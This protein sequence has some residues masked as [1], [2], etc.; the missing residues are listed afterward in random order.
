MSTITEFFLPKCKENWTPYWKAKE[1]MRS[2]QKIQEGNIFYCDLNSNPSLNHFVLFKDHLLRIEN[3]DELRREPNKAMSQALV[4]PLTT[5]KI[6]IY[7]FEQK[8]LN[9]T[10]MVQFQDVVHLPSLPSFSGV[11]AR[12]K[13]CFGSRSSNWCPFSTF[14]STTM[15]FRRKWGRA[16]SRK[17]IKGCVWRT[18]SLLPSRC[19]RKRRF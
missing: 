4:M 5:A 2:K 9:H 15:P 3:L 1:L 10:I 19:L 13:C 12:M 8:H 11:R 17:C 6:S 7:E 16:P 14:S 18:K